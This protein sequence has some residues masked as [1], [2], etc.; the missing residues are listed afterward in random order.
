M[1]AQKIDPRPAGGALLW[2]HAVVLI[3]ACP[4]WAGAAITAGVGVAAGWAAFLAFAAIGTV[5][6]WRVRGNWQVRR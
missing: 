3:V 5:V 1:S 6:V 4:V 2:V